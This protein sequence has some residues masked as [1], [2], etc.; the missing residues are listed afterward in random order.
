MKHDVTP[1]DFNKIHIMLLDRIFVEI[2]K[3]RFTEINRKYE[4]VNT[5]NVLLTQVSHHQVVRRKWYS[6][7]YPEYT[8][9]DPNIPEV[10]G[11]IWPNICEYLGDIRRNPSSPNPITVR[12]YRV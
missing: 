11:T 5:I 3:E 10:Q 7:K 9:Y 4:V 6:A 1:L 8:E 2:Y 12:R